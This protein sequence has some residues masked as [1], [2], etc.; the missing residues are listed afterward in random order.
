MLS[1]RALLAAGTAAVLTPFGIGAGVQNFGYHRNEQL[2]QAYTAH[3]GTFA[4]QASKIEGTSAGKYH[5]MVPAHEKA[6]GHKYRN[7]NQ[8]HYGTCGGVTS[9]LGVEF[10]TTEEDSR[11]RG[12]W[13]G[14]YSS[15]VTYAGARVEVAGGFM[16]KAKIIIKPFQIIPDAAGLR[17]GCFASWAM[18]WLTKWGVLL[19][20]KYGE[21]DLTN[22]DGELARKWGK[23]GH[24]VP[25]ELEPI[26]KEHPVLKATQVKS[27]EEGCDAIYNGYPVVCFGEQGFR[28]DGQRDK[29][30]FMDAVSQWAHVMLWTGFDR[31]PK[32]RQGGEII[33]PWGN[34]SHGPAHEFGS[35]EGSFWADK[36]IVERMTKFEC[37]ALCGFKGYARQAPTFKLG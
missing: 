11:G 34:W 15:E 31:R 5:S 19:R 16:D 22:Y 10:L 35:P 4:S 7:R 32:A 29:Y 2:T 17:D 18:D 23:I 20:G 37:F 13:K 8:L 30:G 3:Y 36:D 14:E 33:N 26:A 1:R 9:T 21:F 27:F 12:L 25:D 24:G 6:I 28:K